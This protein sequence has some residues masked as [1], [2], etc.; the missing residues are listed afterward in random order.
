MNWCDQSFLEFYWFGCDSKGCSL[1]NNEQSLGLPLHVVR[2]MQSGLLSR[3]YCFERQKYIKLINFECSKSG[4]LVWAEAPL[5]ALLN[6]YF[7]S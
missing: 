7:L 2:F 5:M 4:M 1:A 6:C 3:Y